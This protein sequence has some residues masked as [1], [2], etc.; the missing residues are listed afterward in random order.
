MF[1]TQS[2]CSE[3]VPTI[4]EHRDDLIAKATGAISKEKLR[5]AP[6]EQ[7]VV[8]VQFGNRGNK[9]CYA[10]AALCPHITAKTADQLELDWDKLIA[11]TKIG[12]PERQKLLSTHK[13]EAN[14]SLKPYGL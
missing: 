3:I 14:Q 6:N 4:S 2:R 11:A 8:A 9:F 5:I 13:I 1:T 7:P 12:H 10:L